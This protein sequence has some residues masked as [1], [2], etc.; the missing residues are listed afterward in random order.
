MDMT[1]G[2]VIEPKDVERRFLS[3]NPYSEISKSNHIPWMLGL[4]TDEGTVGATGSPS[5]SITAH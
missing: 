5:N 1:F 4:N 3:S 2:P